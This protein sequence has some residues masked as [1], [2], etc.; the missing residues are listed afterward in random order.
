MD[1]TTILQIV[2]SIY[3]SKYEGDKKQKFQKEYTDF[4]KEKPVLFEMA[5][6]KDFDFERFKSML[7]LKESIEKGKISQHDASV[8][9]GNVLY[10][11]YVKNKI[12][13]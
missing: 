10:D 4:A 3:T 2:E 5:C 8:K 11:A 1:A 9:V 13:Q 12:S 6:T 7:V